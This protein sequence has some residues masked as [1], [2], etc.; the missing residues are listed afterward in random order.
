MSLV[1][2]SYIFNHFRKFKKKMYGTPGYGTS[3]GPYSE[4]SPYPDLPQYGVPPAQCMPIYE[5]PAPHYDL[6]SNIEG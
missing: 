3:P 5:P 2:N 6:M 1:C 4:A